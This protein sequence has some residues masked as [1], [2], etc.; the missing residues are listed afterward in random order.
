M[1]KTKK[2]TESTPLQGEALLKRVQELEHLS[3]EE[4]AMECGYFT[5][6]SNGSKRLSLMRFLNAL[7]EAEGIELEGRGPNAGG[8]GGRSASYRLIVQASGNILIGSAYTKKMNLSPGDEFE[9]ELGRKHIR[10]NHI[11]D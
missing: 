8:R 11:N 3:K 7:V 2:K 10:L 1:S 4:K 5:V 6:M 9:V